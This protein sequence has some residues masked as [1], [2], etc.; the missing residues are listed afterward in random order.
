MSGL[1]PVAKLLAFLKIQS[2][3]CSNF[4]TPFSATHC[5]L[6]MVSEELVVVVVGVMLHPQSA[7]NQRQT[8]QNSH[9][10]SDQ[11]SGALSVPPPRKRGLLN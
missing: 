1:P 10:Q 2:A 7:T 11:I 9:A 5:S 6:T 8:A 4:Q 3:H